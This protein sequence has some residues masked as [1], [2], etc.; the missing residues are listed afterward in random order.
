MNLLRVAFWGKI[1]SDLADSADE[2]KLRAVPAQLK[3]SLGI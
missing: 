2:K 3:F 1:M